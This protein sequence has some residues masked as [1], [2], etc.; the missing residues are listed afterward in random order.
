MQWLDTD[1]LSHTPEFCMKK[2]QILQAE[3]ANSASKK[4]KFCKQKTLTLQAI[5]VFIF[6]K[7][8]NNIEY[9]FN[10]EPLFNFLQHR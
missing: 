1:D 5:Q 4:G 2:K 6:T 8:V 10:I 9:Q 7:T 3:K